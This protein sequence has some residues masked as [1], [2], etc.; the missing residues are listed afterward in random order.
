[1][2]GSDGTD[3]AFTNVQKFIVGDTYLVLD[4]SMQYVEEMLGKLDFG[5]DSIS[6]MISP[7]GKEVARIRKAG[8]EGADVLQ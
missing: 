4:L 5:I 3:Y 7:D 8:P 6:A 1:M 2:R